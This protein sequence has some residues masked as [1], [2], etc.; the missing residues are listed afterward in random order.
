[1]LYSEFECNENKLANFL[2]HLLIQAKKIFSFKKN[3]LLNNVSPVNRDYFCNKAIS[4]DVV[5]MG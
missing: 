2:I 1:M 3:H 4:V 5:I